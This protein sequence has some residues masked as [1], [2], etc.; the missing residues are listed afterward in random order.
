MILAFKAIDEVRG[1][2]RGGQPQTDE[3]WMVLVA[4]G[5]QNVIKLNEEH[6]GSDLGALAAG[7]SLYKVPIGL[8]DQLVLPLEAAK[9]IEEAIWFPWDK[10][11]VHCTHGQDRT[12][13]CVAMWRYKV[14][15]W[16]KEKA[17]EE[18]LAN[19]FHQALLGLWLAWLE[20]HDGG[21]YER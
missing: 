2:W 11:F 12:G 3:D 14:C 8:L 16:S 4:K 13:L 19:G 6:E 18:M 7:L 20:A 5:V 10:T 15:G 21:L 1:I 9:R 17:E